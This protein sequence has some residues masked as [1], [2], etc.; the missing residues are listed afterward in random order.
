MKRPARPTQKKRG[1][2]LSVAR[3]SFLKMLAGA[4]AAGAFPLEATLAAAP[5]PTDPITIIVSTGAGGG[6]DLM[7]RGLAQALSREL[8]VPVNVVDKPGGAMVIGTNYFLSQPHDGNTLL[9]AGPSPF[10]YVDINKF[11]AKYKLEDFRILNTQWTD[12]SAVFIPVGS[13]LKSFREIVDAVKARPGELSCGVVRDSGEYF[14]SGI[15]LENLKLPLTAV[16]LVT[17]E[18]SAPLR[19]AIAGSQL[20]FAIVSL[21]ASVT[22]LSLM[23]PVAVFSDNR[24]P[25][26]PDVPTVDEVLKPDGISVDSVPSSLRC[27]IT[28]GDLQEK[29]PE[30]YARLY[31]AYAK[32]LK[33]PDYI[34][35]ATKQGIAVDWLGP[36]KSLAQIKAAYAI[37]DRYKDLLTTL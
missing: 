26:I 28:Y 37:F 11:H 2:R 5:W 35:K 24:A 22:M 3:R 13:K 7:A 30:Q 15:L 36:E 10:W 29:Y 9:V 27:L 23:Q 33:D 1:V 19:T 6:F 18:S 4:A 17:Y 31:D 34:A 20:D 21:D 32:V 25:L 14:N 16:R 12:K 8:G